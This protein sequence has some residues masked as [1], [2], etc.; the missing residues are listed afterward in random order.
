[1]SRQRYAGY[2]LL[3]AFSDPDEK[4]NRDLHKSFSYGTAREDVGRGRNEEKERGNAYLGTR[5]K[6]EPRRL[7]PRSLSK[8]YVALTFARHMQNDFDAG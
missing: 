8:R 3:Q 2:E 5:G 4:A 7:F 1:M 6:L